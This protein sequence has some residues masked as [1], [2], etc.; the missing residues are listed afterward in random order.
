[1]IFH[2]KRSK[3]IFMR[4]RSI[5][6]GGGLFFLTCG[7]QEKKI[8]KKRKKKSLYVTFKDTVLD[9]SYDLYHKYHKLSKPN[10]N[11]IFFFFLFF[12]TYDWLLA[13]LSCELMG[14]GS[15]TKALLLKMESFFPI[16]SVHETY[17]I[18]FLWYTLVNFFFA[19]AML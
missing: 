13:P 19:R 1:M 4:S 14:C 7:I 11:F 9:S 2:G 3:D 15:Y 8:C 6:F 17:K 18:I 10:K 12:N 16:Y 5:N